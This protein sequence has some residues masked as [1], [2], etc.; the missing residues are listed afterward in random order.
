MI[1]RPPSDAL[2]SAPLRRASLSFRSLVGAWRLTTIPSRRRSNPLLCSTNRIISV[3]I[4][5]GVAM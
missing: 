4:S 3:R 2:R 1:D 5:G